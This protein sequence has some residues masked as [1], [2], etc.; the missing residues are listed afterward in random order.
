MTNRTN[1][2]ASTEVGAL[3]NRTT[4]PASAESVCW[5]RWRRSG[6]G[7]HG[8]RGHR[9]STRARDACHRIART[10]ARSDEVWN[11]ASR[12]SKFPF[13]PQVRTAAPAT[14]K[15]QSGLTMTMPPAVTRSRWRCGSGSRND[16]SA[17]PS[18]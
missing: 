10:A 3:R 7:V 12:R 16:K 4:T 2:T 15:T 18:G 13:P 5:P 17:T 9:R 6:F 14:V 1:S 8:R 11:G